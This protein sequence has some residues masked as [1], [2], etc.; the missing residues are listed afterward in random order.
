[1][2]FYLFFTCLFATLLQHP[3]S[4]IRH[5]LPNGTIRRA[6]LGILVGATIVAIVLTPWGKQSG[7]HLDP[8]MPSTF[9][10]LRKLEFWG[11]IFYGAAQFAG[12]T[13]GVVVATFSYLSR[14]GTRRF[15]TPQHFPE[16]TA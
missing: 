7:D 3:A 8:A 12:A 5:L 4:P 15:A 6:C 16:Y 2:G 9:Y 14:P 13:A 1:M 10:P 11:A